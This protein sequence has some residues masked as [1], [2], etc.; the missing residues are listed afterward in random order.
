MKQSERRKQ[1]TD[2][3]IMA[4][5][6]LAAEKGVSALTFDNIG[7]RAGYSRNLAFQKFG[8]KA[9][10]LQA[11]IN[12]LHDAMTEIRE[13]RNLEKL[14][15]LDALRLYCDVHVSS[16]ERAPDMRAYFILM[17]EAVSEQSEMRALFVKSHERS[18]AEIQ[19]L[20]Q[21]GRADGSIRKDINVEMAALI[22]GTQLIGISSEALIDPDFNLK[23]A[24]KE[25]R[26]LISAAYG[27]RQD[28]G[29]SA[30][31]QASAARS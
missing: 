17:S 1:S 11:V 4:C 13:E 31:L 10:L 18:A 22:I 26:F 23:K 15:G 14:N 6:E 19:R 25:L 5:L 27:A 12:Y 20:I 30:R 16:T 8:S 9:G 28:D 2:K 7:E 21:R 24:R 3:L 29:K